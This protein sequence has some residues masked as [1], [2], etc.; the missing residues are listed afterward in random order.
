[1]DNEFD[2]LFLYDEN[3]IS[4][5]FKQNYI[6]YDAAEKCLPAYIVHFKIEENKYK[7][8]Q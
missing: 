8:L 6:V 5:E 2:S 3:Y 1:M 7:E 4:K